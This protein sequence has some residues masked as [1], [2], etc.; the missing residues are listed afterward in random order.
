MALED[1]R[2]SPSQR[3]SQQKGAQ[4]PS[5]DAL[6]EEFKGIQ[7]LAELAESDHELQE[8]L[9]PELERLKAAV[10]DALLDIWLSGPYDVNSA[11]IDV[12]AGTGGAD[13]CDWASMLVRMYTK[14][15]HARNHS[16]NVVS[17]SPGDTIGIKA[18][19][20]HIQGRRVYGYARHESGVHRL[21]R[22]SPVD[23]KGV[24]HTSFASV[25]VSPYFE[26]HDWND[27]GI[28]LNDADL[29][30]TTMRSQGPGGQHVNKTESA[31]RVEHIPTG[32]TVT[33]QQ[34]RQQ[35]VNRKL[36]I[37]LLRSKLYDLEMKKREKSKADMHNE[38]LDISWGSQIRSYVLHPYQLIKDHRTGYEVTGHKQVDAVLG[39]EISE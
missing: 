29:R 8:E 36:A 9:I 33:C 22:A 2:Q 37:D 30:I 27:V 24:R 17:E 38:L 5:I 31:V 35:S 3:S 18:A 26:K 25:Q 1:I 19:T 15:A 21:V 28:K 4:L 34:Q 6:R 32:M 14:W 11:Y 20:I 39:G 12:H 13:A 16:V 23:G 10:D 7:E